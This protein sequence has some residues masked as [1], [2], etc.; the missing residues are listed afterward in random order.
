MSKVTLGDGRSGPRTAGK[1]K[2]R[3]LQSDGEST[4]T[5]AVIDGARKEQHLML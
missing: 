4:C 1:S 3:P 5:G 2:R